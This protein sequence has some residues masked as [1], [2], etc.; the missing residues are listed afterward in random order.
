[1]STL[2]LMMMMLVIFAVGSLMLRKRM[3]KVK[4]CSTL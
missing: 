2:E 3:H 1:M 4:P